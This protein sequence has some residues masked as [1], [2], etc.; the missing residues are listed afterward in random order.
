MPGCSLPDLLCG[1]DAARELAPLL[2]GRQVVA[3][4]RARKAALRRYAQVLQR[5]V[6]RRLLYLAL[7]EV[8]R[9]QRAALGGHQAE[10]HLLSRRQMAQRLEA[11]GAGGVEFHEKAVDVAREHRLGDRRVIAFGD[12]G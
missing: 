7:E 3:V 10:D 6:A 12:P 8:L 1:L 9:L 5:H 4:V 2:V 11:A